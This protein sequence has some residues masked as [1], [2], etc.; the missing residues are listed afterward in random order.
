MKLV[1]CLSCLDVRTPTPSGQP[2]A[3]RC[4]AVSAHTEGEL[5]HVQAKN[6]EGVRLLCLHDDAIAY[7][8]DPR[9]LILGQMGWKNLNS[10]ITSRSMNTVYHTWQR[11]NWAALCH[12]VEV[13]GVVWEDLEAEVNTDAALAGGSDA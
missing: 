1:L 9:S 3:C 12:W 11:G 4:G 8:R 6:R 2:V 10:E 13:S 5:L 7:S